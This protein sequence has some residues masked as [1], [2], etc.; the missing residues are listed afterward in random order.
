VLLSL[1]HDFRALGRN[2]T[3]QAFDGHFWDFG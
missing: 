3:D 2:L 1:R